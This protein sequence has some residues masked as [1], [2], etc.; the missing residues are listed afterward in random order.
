MADTEKKPLTLEKA[1]LYRTLLRVAFALVAFVAPMI[2]IGLK[3]QIFTHTTTTKISITALLLILIVA[4][5]FRKRISDWIS[6]W[7][8]DHISKHILIA[9]GKVWPFILIAGILALIKLQADAIN[10]ILTDA[11]TCLQWTCV[12]ELFAY[13][14]LYPLEMKMD[15]QVKRLIRKQERKEDLKEAIKELQES[16]NE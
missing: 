7:E 13:L 1:K 8:D 10:Q 12:L 9:I 4:W 6:S 11:L 15:Y 16:E 2:I 5:R 3:F 14:I